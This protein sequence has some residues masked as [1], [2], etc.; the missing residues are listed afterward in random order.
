MKEI[1]TERS[2]DGL[3]AIHIRLKRRAHNLPIMAQRLYIK[4]TPII[5]SSLATAS[6]LISLMGPADRPHHN[7]TAP[8]ASDV[9]LLVTGTDDNP[10]NPVP[11]IQDEEP[12]QHLRDFI[13][14]PTYIACRTDEP[15]Y[16]HQKKTVKAEPEMIFPGNPAEI[17][18]SVFTIDDIEGDFG[19]PVF[20]EKGELDKGRINTLIIPVGF[21]PSELDSEVNDRMELLSKGF[22]GVDVSFSRLKD[23]QPIR[24]LRNRHA[25]LRQDDQINTL[26]AHIKR[27][28]ARIYDNVIVII[29]SDIYMGGSTERIA[30]VAG[31]KTNKAFVLLHEAAHGLGLYDAYMYNMSP[32]D[33]KNSSEHTLDPDLSLGIAKWAWDNTKPKP[34][35]TPS[36]AVCDGKTI[37]RYGDDGFEGFNMMERVKDDQIRERL[38][39]G[40]GVFTPWQINYMNATIYVRT[41][42]KA[43]APPSP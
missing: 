8:S 3:E 7:E 30:M 12:L 11:I 4:A 5:R 39:G 26:L 25:V 34:K 18:S 16:D 2:H 29:N 22:E 41:L 31:E 24:I 37:Y 1:L 14:P 32:D 33:L 17:E 28:T 40:K 10:D 27:D 6:V 15:T 19:I 35:L 21:S 42:D 23:S 9:I 20:D 13:G 36:G 43:V 38:S